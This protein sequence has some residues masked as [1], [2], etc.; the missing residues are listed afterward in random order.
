MTY[1][2]EVA[3]S[4]NL[5][6]VTRDEQSLLRKSRV[7]IAGLGGVGGL[8]LTTLCRIGVGSFSI[9]DYDSFELANFNRQT[10]AYIDTVGHNKTDVMLDIV[11]RINP[12]A[13]V[14][15]FREGISESNI[16]EFL[17]DADVVV[18]GLDYFALE[19][20]DLLYTATRERGIPV[21]AAGPLGCSV[22]LLVFLPDRMSW[23]EYF[24]IDVHGE[25]TRQYILFAIGTG[26][27]GLHIPYI[28][29]SSVSLQDKAGPSLSA[30]VHLCAGVVGIEVLKLL[31][32]RGPVYPAPYYQ[33]FDAYRCKYYRGKLRWGNRGPIQRLKYLLVR[34]M[35]GNQ[36][37]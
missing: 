12:S 31:L 34:R 35:L 24:S 1:S 33:Q 19:A 25:E 27:R 32:G 6:L 13:T 30:A 37:E 9:A 22:A 15:S 3:F 36:S 20:R 28:D 8:H 5:G 29:K 7:A 17:E 21:V 11:R 18:D 16:D 26:P 2:Y 23:H 14:S 10:G 4:R